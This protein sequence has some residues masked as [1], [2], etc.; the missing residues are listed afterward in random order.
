[1]LTVR[2]ATLADLDAIVAMR[3]ALL[4]EADD[5]PVYHR[6]RPD[7]VTRA[8]RLFRQQLESGDEVTFLAERDG[9]ALGVLRCAES[10]GSPLLE[11]D[12]Y[13]YVSSVYVMPPA[14]RTGVLRALLE[15]ASAWCTSRGLDEMRLHSVVDAGAANAAWDA[16]GFTIVEH[17]RVR[18]LSPPGAELRAASESRATP[19]ASATRGAAVGSPRADR[20]VPDRAAAPAALPPSR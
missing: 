14:R 2:A 18:P 1:M 15:Q 11:P 3:L 9:A 4:E 6:L 20:F 10:R 16:L 5:N 19:R 7:A 17:L 13:A 12:R 8:R